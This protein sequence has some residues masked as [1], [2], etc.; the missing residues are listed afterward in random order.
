[1]PV[2]A[3]AAFDPAHHAW[4]P[5]AD[6]ALHLWLLPHRRGGRS[7]DALRMGIAGYLDCAADNIELQRDAHGRPVLLRPPGR[8]RF[9]A[10]HSGDA[11]LLGFTLG[12]CIGVDIECRKPR[13]HALQL[14]RRYFTADEA[15][16]LTGMPHTEREDAFYR[17]W[18]A[19]EAL[20]KAIGHG[21]AHGLDRVGL[22][23]VDDR[24]QLRELQLPP[25][26]MESAAA[27]AIPS[28]AD[29]RLLE[30]APLPGYRACIAYTGAT[31][32]VRGWRMT[33]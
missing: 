4:P 10:S 25:A 24:L 29:W 33:A 22:D 8:L 1:M 16:A 26:Q 13:P 12:D 14:A 28:S 31:R 5:L 27:I 19:K 6:D 11:L 15:A 7:T 32:V 21:L 2:I 20:L 17:L 30:C 23:F 3:F 18:I 9:S